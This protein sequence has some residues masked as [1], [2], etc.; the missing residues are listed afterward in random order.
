MAYTGYSRIQICD[1]QERVNDLD[2]LS[3]IYEVEF[4]HVLR[5]ANPNRHIYVKCTVS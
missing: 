5:S 2:W 4:V 3:K 1:G